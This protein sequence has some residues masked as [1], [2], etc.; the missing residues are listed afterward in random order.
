MPES[1]VQINGDANLARDLERIFSKLDPDWE[2][3]LAG[4][5]GDTA[6]YQAAQGIRQGI[7]TARETA[8]NASRILADFM[9]DRD[10]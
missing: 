8:R 10:S 1:K 5:L 2:G 7:E 3:P 6:G 4:M 9:K